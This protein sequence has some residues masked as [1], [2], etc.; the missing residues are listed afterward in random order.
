MRTIKNISYFVY[1]ISLIGACLT[2]FFS[3]YFGWG[4][5]I[6]ILHFFMISFIIGALTSCAT[7]VWEE[8]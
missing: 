8:F 5:T 4:N 3:E 2:M 7:E 6:N 1:F